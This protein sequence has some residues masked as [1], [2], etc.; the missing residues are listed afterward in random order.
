MGWTGRAVQ[1]FWFF[2]LGQRA[3]PYACYLPDVT[4][5]GTVAGLLSVA[6]DITEEKQARQKS[7][8]FLSAIEA[9]PDAIAL[10]DEGDRLVAYNKAYQDLTNLDIGGLP[11]TVSQP[12]PGL[13]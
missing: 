5:D 11:A 3:P 10:F 4:A 7:E 1:K 8:R 9:L 12:L 13:E 2:D 6:E